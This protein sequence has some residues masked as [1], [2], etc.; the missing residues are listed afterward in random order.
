MAVAD[1]R[2]VRSAGSAPGGGMEHTSDKMVGADASRQTEHLRVDNYDA[3]LRPL[4][5]GDTALLNELTVGVFW[6]HRARDLDVFLALG[7]GYLALDAIDRAMGSSMYFLSGDDFAML[8]M[9]VT[10][11]RLQSMGTGRWLLHHITQDCE[12]RDLR[13]SATRSG[14]R[15]YES[16]GFK[17]LGLIRQH[18]GIAQKIQTP[19]PAPGV[20]IRPMQAGD[21]SAV[22]DLDATAY[23][24]R[25]TAILDTMRDLSDGLVAERGGEIC[26]FALARPFGR[27]VVIGPLVAEHDDVAMML[28]A[29]F[30]Q[31]HEGAFVRLDT[32]VQSEALSAF[33]VDAGLNCADTVTEMFTGTQRRPLKGT[34]IY[35]LASHSLG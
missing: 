4:S 1:C 3:I 14:Y 16:D 25:R 29:P 10:A 6:P 34:Q 12:G 5:A 8:G 13:L 7:R 31:R 22:A 21:A 11:P 26:G 30:I 2:H 28:A 9:M 19:P 33:L 24:A 15:L 20:A 18:Q 27:G 35:G 17:P 32:P 23:G